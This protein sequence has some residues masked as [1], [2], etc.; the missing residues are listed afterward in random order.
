MTPWI[1][2]ASAMVFLGSVALAQFPKARG[3]QIGY[4]IITPA[5][6]N[7]DGL[8][9]VE[10][11][12]QLTLGGAVETKVS[13]SPILTRAAM[14]AS[15]GPLTD[16]ATGVA[17]VNP[18]VT[19]CSVQLSLTGT[20]GTEILSE[21][22]SVL[23]HGQFSR[24][25]NELF[26]SA[27]YGT[28]GLTGLLTVT[29]DVPV[30][31][32]GLNFRGAG[33]AAVPLASLSSPS[34]LSLLMTSTPSDSAGS[35]TVVVPIVSVMPALPQNSGSTANGVSPAAPVIGGPGAF[36]FPQV[37]SGSGW[38]TTFT[39]ANTSSSP[40]TIRIDFYDPNGVALR[41]VVKVT[42]PSRGLYN[43]VQ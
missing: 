27:P 42:I 16:G 15:V 6:G 11:L 10:T 29:A 5:S 36:V 39:I 33:F 12:T 32:L 37:A 18:N 22:I 2:V 34:P 31:V 1:R 25:L 20:D 4:A 9:P 41:S 7:S 38:S 26:A 13:P 8:V 43:L 19:T 14:P 3:P 35:A 40:Q 21:A 17:I 23:P 28:S 30:A 24:F